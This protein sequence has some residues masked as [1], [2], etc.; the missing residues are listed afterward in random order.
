MEEHTAAVQASC[1]CCLSCGKQ[2]FKN[3]LFLL[4]SFADA[5]SS[6]SLG[7]RYTDPVMELGKK[8]F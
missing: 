4:P 2:V 5:L 8:Y 6:F 7:H 3:E 1:T